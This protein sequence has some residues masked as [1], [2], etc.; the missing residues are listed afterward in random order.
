MYSVVVVV[1][2]HFLSAHPPTKPAP[3]ASENLWK[4][5]GVEPIP[6]NQTIVGRVDK[7]FF[8]RDKICGDALSGKSVRYMK[9]LNILDE[10]PKLDGSTINRITFGSPSHK[11]FDINLTK[12]K[13]WIPQIQHLIVT[14]VNDAR[15]VLY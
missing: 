2:K 3:M 8:P 7:S 11:Q 5:L 9:E 15:R 10:V 13:A 4:P 14:V 12:S 1:G 6:P